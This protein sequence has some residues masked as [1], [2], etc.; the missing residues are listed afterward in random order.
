[1]DAIDQ[2]VGAECTEWPPNDVCIGARLRFLPERQT[3]KR[4]LVCISKELSGTSKGKVRKLTA[5][6]ISAGVFSYR[7]N[8]WGLSVGG[9]FATST[10]F[11]Y[12][13]TTERGWR[14]IPLSYCVSK[15]W[16][17]E[18][19]KPQNI[20]GDYV[21]FPDHSSF[22]HDFKADLESFVW[23][24]GLTLGLFELRYFELSR[25]IWKYCKWVTCEWQCL[26]R[27]IYSVWMWEL[28]KSLKQENSK[29][30]EWPQL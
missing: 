17:G 13:A 26:F 11:F 24:E 4:P 25:S 21:R 6:L 22:S 10:A 29:T 5:H 27:L 19:E 8:G 1:M 9:S 14:W 18:I 30:S 16:L 28:G 20:I 15:G 2:S 7:R 3:T 23:I 12:R